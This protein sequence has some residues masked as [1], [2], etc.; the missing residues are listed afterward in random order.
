[1]NE[2]EIIEKRFNFKYPNLYKK[3]YED[4]MLDTGGDYGP[5]WSKTYYAKFEKEPTLLFFNDFELLKFD[6]IIEEIEAFKNPEDYR[7][8]KPEHQFIPFAQNRAGDLFVFQMDAKKGKDIPI[9]FLWHDSETGIILACNLQDFIF[10]MLLKEVEIIDKYSTLVTIEGDKTNAHNV[11]RTHKPYLKDKHYN[12][13]TA[14][15]KK[16]LSD[17]YHEQGAKSLI[18]KEEKAEILRHEIRFDKFNHEFVYMG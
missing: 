17:N 14:I 13:L 4:G 9:T 6:R 2:L 3:L 11:L 8:T 1:M 15:Y 10:R 16:E 12:I 5:D 18:T 7:K